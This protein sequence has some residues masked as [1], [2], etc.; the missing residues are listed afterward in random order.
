MKLSVRAE[1]VAQPLTSNAEEFKTKGRDY[2]E[3]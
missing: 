1:A 2:Q 3:P